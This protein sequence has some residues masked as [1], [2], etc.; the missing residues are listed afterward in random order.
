MASK[1]E[2][3]AA[4]TAI[5]L[6][7]GGVTDSGRQSLPYGTTVLSVLSEWMRND[8]LEKAKLALEAAERVRN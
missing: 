7:A 8:V 5:A 2:I 6:H 4:A 1:A 3:E